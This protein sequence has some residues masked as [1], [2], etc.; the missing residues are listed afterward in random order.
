MSIRLKL[1][2]TIIILGA[3]VVITLTSFMTVHN[4]RVLMDSTV[5]NNQ[6]IAAAVSISLDNYLDELARTTETL[7]TSHLIVE[8]VIA[9][10]RESG[11]LDP[12]E[13]K[14]RSNELNEKWMGITDS[15]DPFIQEY[16]SNSVARHLRE[17]ERVI[18]DLYGEIFV[19]N[20]YG[21]L[22][23]ATGRLTTF[24]HGDKYWWLSTFN[25]GKGRVF[26]DDRGYDLSVEDFVLGVTVPIYHKG[27][28]IGVLKSN[29]KIF[30]LFSRVVQDYA[31][32]YRPG[33][34]KIARTDGQVV[35]E[36]NEPPLS[37][38]VC[39]EFRPQLRDE[40]LSTHYIDH[41]GEEI[42]VSVSPIKNTTELSR[43]GFGG[44]GGSEDH[45]RGNTDGKWVVL[46]KL[47][48][49][50]IKKKIASQTRQF[51]LIGFLSIFAISM[52]ALFLV[53]KA[54]GNIIRLVQ[55][56]DEVGRG[57]LDRRVNI[58]TNDE[59]GILA[60]SFNEMLTNLKQTTA[61]KDE[62]L[63]EMQKR[64]RAEKILKHLSTV[65]ELTQL[66]NRR[67]FND[68]MHR[69]ITHVRHSDDPLAITLLDIDDF[70]RINDSFGHDVGD[71]VLVEF[72]TVLRDNVR[73]VDILSRW[74]GEEFIIIMPGTNA[75]EARKV[76]ERLR[77]AVENFEFTQGI[78]ITASFGV[79]E[80]R[81][82]D[83]FD[84]LLKRVDDA[85]SK[86]KADGKNVV[87]VL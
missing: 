76:A 70:K 73:E 42:L 4:R 32:M 34:V 9:S 54:T 33:I 3:M 50:H 53:N 19:T 15:D 22:I 66:Y 23:A 79:T 63:K 44:E 57:N 25:D 62:L 24:Y 56:T 12:F 28:C 87:A 72:A 51:L 47:P 86:A 27:E 29:M 31:A 37:T 26:F 43:F 59:I 16:L 18:P 13:R 41:S 71:A 35:L 10:N 48:K 45:M 40:I 69:A 49:E 75:P 38:V 74:G 52:A 2:T 67:A 80:F 39:Q 60:K 8:S 68:N 58:N 17:Q 65:D 77:Q 85:Q 78:S 84:S 30:S 20:K 55:L 61:S 14:Q 6:D 46:L 1:T 81:N 82:S 21:E 5:Q 83:T 11:L 7:A 64:R 36:P